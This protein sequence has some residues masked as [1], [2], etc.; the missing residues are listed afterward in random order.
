MSPTRFS[1]LSARVQ[2]KMKK[3]SQLWL[4][5]VKNPIIVNKNMNNCLIVPTSFHADVI[6][7]WLQGKRIRNELDLKNEK[8][9]Y[10]YLKFFNEKD[11]AL[12]VEAL[13]EL[14]SKTVEKV[15]KLITNLFGQE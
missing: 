6:K 12:L 4:E 1:E 14:N 7:E 15:E 2:E 11:M 8:N 3:N 13:D 9:L 5:K 10:A